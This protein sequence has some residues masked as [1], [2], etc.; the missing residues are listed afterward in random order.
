[1]ATEPE[2]I[3]DYILMKWKEVGPMDISEAAVQSYGKF[4]F[5]SIK[6]KFWNGE[7][8]GMVKGLCNGVGRIIACDGSA[9]FEGRIKYNVRNGYGRF[10]NR[11][12]VFWEGIWKHDKKFK[13]HLKLTLPDEET[14]I[15]HPTILTNN[16]QGYESSLSN[17][18]SPI[19]FLNKIV[20]ITFIS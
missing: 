2:D 8:R 10:F 19:K 1:M 16:F 4:T 6:V 13:Q 12:G 15:N 3:D 11:D 18:I 17:R 20:T 9:M 5:G 14:S 7:F